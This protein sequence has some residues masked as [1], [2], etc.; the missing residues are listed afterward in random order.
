MTY[1]CPLRCVHCYTD[2]GR[3]SA[4]QLPLDGM[5]RLADLLV[6]MA[7]RMMHIGGGE[8]LLIPEL[9]PVLERLR[10]GG[11]PVVLSTSGFGVT[12]E[13]AAELA[14]VCH[15]IHVSVDGP[16]A[17]VHDPIRGRAGS[18][19]ESVAALE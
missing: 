17:P 3:R 16:D 4:R 11:L 6:G 2:G 18:F 15:S 13:V 9:I 19:D 1:A 5:L 12:D 10:S 8:P 14:R 7:P